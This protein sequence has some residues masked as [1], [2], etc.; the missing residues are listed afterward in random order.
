MGTRLVESDDIGIL[1]A[2]WS[3]LFFSSID[4]PAPK[5][6]ILVSE[7]YCLVAA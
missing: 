4:E 3:A 5:K 7:R 1:V 6:S 2:Q